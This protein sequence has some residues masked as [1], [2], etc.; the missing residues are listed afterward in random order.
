[1]VKNTNDVNLLTAGTS[2]T[3]QEY[4]I[5]TYGPPMENEDTKIPNQTVET[6]QPQPQE[7]AHKLAKKFG[8]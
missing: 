1:M 8:R 5:Q 2:C 4:I 7:V 6:L 3:W